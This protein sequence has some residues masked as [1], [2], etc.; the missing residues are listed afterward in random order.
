MNQ[1]F[2]NYQDLVEAQTVKPT[3]ARTVQIRKALM[4]LKKECDTQRKQLLPV[5]VKVEPTVETVEPVKPKDEMP[6]E[7][8]P[9]VREM[10]VDVSSVEPVK[11]IEI[12]V[13]KKKRKA[14]TMKQ[15]L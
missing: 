1:A 5:K 4:T 3:K 2:Q 9:L 7:P 15:S 12:E 10:T 8:P 14:K 11:S 13:K 6:M